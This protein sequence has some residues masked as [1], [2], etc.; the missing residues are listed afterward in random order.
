MDLATI[1]G[2]I[3]GTVLIVGSIVIGGSALIFI[4]VPSLLIVCGGTIA[5]TFIKFTM[6]DVI[7]SINVAMKAF[8]V[9]MEAPENIIK[10]MVEFTRIAKKE[11]L[12]ALEK[13]KPS[14]PFSAK[15]LR[16]LS[17]GYDEGLIADMLNKDIR[18]MS[19]RHTTGQ[20]VFKG[21]GDSAPAFGMIGTL[22]GLVQMLT[23]MSDPSA[24]GPSMAVAL[25]TTMYGA[26]MANLV[27]L[28]IAEKLTLRSEQ[29]RLNKSIIVEAAIAINRG[30]SPMVL[31]ESLK[32][33]LS[34][35][36][37]QKTEGEKTKTE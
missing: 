37:R 36:E 11:G 14:D 13:E 32:I 30:V 5:V 15:A 19:Q 27:A 4:N 34:P 10:E 26:V 33:F 20:N 9:K 17:D 35:K 29:E 21:M 31:E 18:L 1:I 8:L 25:L 23:S 3:S 12:I 22:I 2:L 7:G 28:P 24:I 16:Y 6:A